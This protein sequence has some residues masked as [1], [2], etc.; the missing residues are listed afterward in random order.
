[1]VNRRTRAKLLDQVI[2][3][4][5][6]EKLSLGRVDW[7]DI[8]FEAANTKGDGY[9]VVVVDETQDLSAN[10]LRA[11]L[12]HLKDDHVT[13]FIIDAVQRIYPRSF[14]WREIGIE[15]RP[16]MVFRLSKNH[17]NTREIAR[18]ASSLVQDLPPEEDGVTP[19]EQACPRS[20]TRPE[21]V[22]GS[23]SAQL[24]HMLERVKP[25]LDAG[26]TVGILQPRGRLVQ[27]RENDFATAQNRLL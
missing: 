10:Q 12:A 3:P 27:L 7:N 14:T 17:R 2:K 16:E 21:V 18:F 5:E 22:A 11:V 8:A 19:N 25:H 6:E 4:Y 26:E 13:T 20:G 23:Y 9:D 15:I 24:S 1:M